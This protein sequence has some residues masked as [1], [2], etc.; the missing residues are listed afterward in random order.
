MN[1]YLV[2]KLNGVMQSWGGHTF[3]D[4]RHTEIMPTRSAILGLLAACLGIDRTDQNS[5]KAL[6][7]SIKMAIRADQRHIK[8]Q[9][10]T[11]FHTVENARNVE[12]KKRPFPITSNREYLCDAIFTVIL[13]QQ[14]KSQYPLKT[15]KKA[16]Q[17]PIYTPFLGR[18]ACPINRPLY[19]A[20]LSALNFKTAFALLD[21]IAGP[22]YSDTRLDEKDI[23]RSIRDQPL[24][25]R[26]RQF[27]NRTYYI[28]QNT[29]VNHV[30]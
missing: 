23:V 2:L 7:Q 11:D 25:Q 19:E 24:Y 27:A 17:D 21:Q 28:H 29:G 12:G 16:L 14:P 6:G 9:C 30:P 13:E 8:T 15:I 26:S 20:E 3:E 1:D 18:R 4:L 22:I 5:Q 10:I